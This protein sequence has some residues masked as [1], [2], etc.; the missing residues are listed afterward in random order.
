MVLRWI[1]SFG[2]ALLLDKAGNE[3]WKKLMPALDCGA[4]K[5]LAAV[6]AASKAKSCLVSIFSSQSFTE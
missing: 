4:V 6:C 5:A 1:Q 2:D 3:D